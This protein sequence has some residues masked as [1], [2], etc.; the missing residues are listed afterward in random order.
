M[1][2]LLANGGQDEATVATDSGVTTTT[3]TARAAEPRTARVAEV[4]ED[5]VTIVVA[6]QREVV[7]VIGIDLP[8]TGRSGAAAQCYGAE[9]L[10]RATQ[11]LASQTVTVEADA[12]FGARDAQGRQ[13]V[14]LR[15]PT[16][17]LFGEVMLTEGF[18]REQGVGQPYQHKSAHQAAEASARASGAGLWAATTCAGLTQAP[19]TTA[20]PVTVPPSTAPPATAPPTTVPRTPPTPTP[21]TTSPP[22]RSSG[23]YANCSEARAAGAAPLYR[24][25]PG[26]AA[27]L[28]RDGDGVACE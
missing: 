6:D 10:A 1:V 4:T 22:P 28:D 19:P 24:G 7:R 21:T 11:L 2:A 8:D 23:P 17:R 25:D 16:G 9:A 18:A 3:A 13:Q 14:Y 27:K 15:L 5:A 26:Y 20:P 12:A